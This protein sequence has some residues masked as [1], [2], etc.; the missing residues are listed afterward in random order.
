LLS[1]VQA[2]FG[3]QPRYVVALWA[4]ESD[5][6]RV[7]GDF[8]EVGALATLAFE[9]SRPA[10]FRAELIDALHILDQ[11]DVAVDRM[12]GSWAGA[13]GQCQFMPSS[14]RR[15]AVDFDGDGRR[16]IWTSR[17][18]VFASIA[19]Y[20]ASYHWRPEQGWGREVRLPHGFDAHLIGAKS[21]RLLRDWRRLGLRD[22]DG[23]DLP[24]ASLSAYLVAPD[25][26]RGRTFLVYANYAIVMKWNHSTFFATSV[27]LLADRIAGE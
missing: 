10:M 25:G 22:P 6:G 1:K 8:S 21:A 15:Y 19:N 13:M 11:G 7:T 2:T 20:L 27:G 9:G 4:V 26:P 12:T 5:Y 23:S 3:V 16:D 18:D 14:F 24:K 17:A